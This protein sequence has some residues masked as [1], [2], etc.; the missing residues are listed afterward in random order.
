[1][2][3]AAIWRFLN[4]QTRLKR[5]LRPEHANQ[6]HTGTSVL[7]RARGFTHNTIKILAGYLCRCV[8]DGTILSRLSPYG[9]HW[10]VSLLRQF[11]RPMRNGKGVLRMA[12]GCPP[13]NARAPAGTPG[14]IRPAGHRNRTAA[15]RSFPTARIWR[16]GEAGSVLALV[17]LCMP[18]FMMLAGLA[19]DCGLL[20]VMRQELQAIADFGALAG[21]QEVDLEALSAGERKFL[22]QAPVLTATQYVRQNIASA[23]RPW[24][25]PKQVHV[26]ARTYEPGPGREVVHHGDGRLLRDPT[27]CVT[28]RAEIR[29]PL[30]GLLRGPLCLEA[31]AD[32]SILPRDD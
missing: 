8:A 11:R 23:L 14:P 13:L 29:P 22:P 4:R 7:S 5:K 12:S 24:L 30:I 10:R 25:K 1:M 27:V 20:F 21:V 17:A 26:E 3:V 2:S 28:V 9:T 18:A 15:S 6:P 19:L 32:A 31:H 16:T